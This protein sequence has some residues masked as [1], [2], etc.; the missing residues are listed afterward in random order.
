M[1]TQRLEFTGAQGQTLAGRLDQPDDEP[2]AYALFAHCFTC[3]KDI[4]AAS[5]VAG[6]LAEQGIATLR[7]DFTGLGGSEGDFGNSGFRS[8][9]ADLVAAAGFMRDTGRPVSILVGHSLGGAAVLAAASE[10]PECQAV[11]TVAAP[12]QADHVLA[13]L[14]EK[15]SEIEASGEATVTLGGRPFR[16]G[17]SFLE[18]TLNQNQATRISELR[19]P[20]LVLHAP[21]DDVVPVDNARRIFETAKHPKSYVSLDDADHLLTRA[22]DARYAATVIAAWAARYLPEPPTEET[23]DAAPGGAVVV[24]ETGQGQFQQRVRA[25][26]HRL[27]ADE[28][29]ANGG[30]DTGPDPYGYLLA[31]LG[32]CTAMTIRMY[33]RHKGIDLQDVRVALDHEKVHARDCE[34][35]ATTEGRIDRI[36][37]RIRLRGAFDAEQHQ[38]LLAMADRCPVHRT[39]HGEIDVVTRS[40]DD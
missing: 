34:H 18:E 24:E 23:D 3:G 13:H 32:S 37:R 14:G 22:S 16:I 9:V 27:L 1:R 31:A 25:G 35:C 40:E 33:A 20:V 30:D 7:F 29:A 38:R 2:L 26:R 28:P 12:F 19:R 17:R 21:M 36:T 11:A 10:V 8:N 5:R 39:L 15:R 4:K 6:A